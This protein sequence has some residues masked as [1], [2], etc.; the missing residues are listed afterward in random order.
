MLTVSSDD[1]SSMKICLDTEIVCNLIDSR[2]L[3]ENL[4]AFPSHDP[5]GVDNL[6]TV[7]HYS[8][9]D[10][11]RKIRTY[12]NY[13]SKHWQSLYDIKQD[14]TPENNMF[15]DKSWSDVTENETNEMAKK[16]SDDLG[17]WI[18]HRKVDFSNPTPWIEWKK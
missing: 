6:P 13:W 11:N 18:F 5:A 4:F 2:Q 16:L 7:Y 1:T 14:D 15:F 17:G 9:I 12:K 8:W 10:I 3:T